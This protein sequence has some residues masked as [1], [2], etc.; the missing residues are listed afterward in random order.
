MNAGEY[1][2]RLLA[3]QQRLVRNIHLAG[4]QAREVSDA[5]PADLG[6]A[7]V[8]DEEKDARF[9]AAQA[10]LATLHQVQAALQRIEAGTFGKCLA[11]GGPIEERR[12]RAIPWTPYCLKHERLQETGSPRRMPT[13]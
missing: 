11:D 1:K 7:S 13:L 10:D 5:T 9:D 8:R 3:E 12:L 2:Q 6:D 4:A